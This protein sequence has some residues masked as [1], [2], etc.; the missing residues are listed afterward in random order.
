MQMGRTSYR[1]IVIWLALIALTLLSLGS[2][3]TDWHGD[4]PVFAVVIVSALI[5][6]RL[7]IYEFMEVRRAPWMLRLSMDGWVIVLGTVLLT[8]FA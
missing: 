8:W 4:V 1:P 3:E 6:V 2:R 5:K 7:V